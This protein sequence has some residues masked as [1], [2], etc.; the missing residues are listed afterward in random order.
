[1]APVATPWYDDP[2]YWL[3]GGG[4]VLLFILFGGHKK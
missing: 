3:V 2:V 4:L 1:V